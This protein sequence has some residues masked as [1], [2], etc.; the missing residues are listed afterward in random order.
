MGIGTIFVSLYGC[1]IW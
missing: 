1:K